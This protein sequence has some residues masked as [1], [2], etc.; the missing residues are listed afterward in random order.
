M[1]SPL[2]QSEAV[3]TLESLARVPDAHFDLGLTLLWVATLEYPYLDI[4]EYLRRFEILAEQL[5]SRLNGY[6]SPREKVEKLARFMSKECGFRGNAEA[7]Y[8]A[9]NSFLNDVLDRYLGIPISL[10]AVYLE[11]AR[12]TGID[13]YGVGFPFHFLVGTRASSPLFIDPFH[14]GRL[15]DPDGCRDLLA[16]LTDRR[17]A[18]DT[19]FLNEV[20]DREIVV[21]VLRNLKNIHVREARF[22]RAIVESSLILTWSPGDT[23]EFRDRGRMRLETH[24]LS[25]G[26]DDLEEYLVR[27]PE[28]DD[29][30]DVLRDLE[31]ARH[32][33]NTLN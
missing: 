17:L 26:I 23:G 33:R 31:H 11:V 27:E 20:S 16:H 2:A 8:D 7:Y 3:S 10:S 9:R 15:M 14:Q 12:R 6:E 22:E 21:R 19:A 1:D 32:I 30:A 13:I 25:G 28:A 24:D 18:F 29:Q 4:G 5:D